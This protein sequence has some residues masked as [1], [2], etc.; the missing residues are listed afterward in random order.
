MKNLLF[1]IINKFN[2]L[3]NLYSEKVA[4]AVAKYQNKIYL[5]TL[6]CIFKW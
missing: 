6:R 5:Y 3:G 1:K 4:M 2:D